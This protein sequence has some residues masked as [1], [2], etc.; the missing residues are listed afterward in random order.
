MDA[1][2]DRNVHDLPTADTDELLSQLRTVADGA[3]LILTITTDAPRTLLDAVNDISLATR[4]AWLSANADGSAIDIGP[5]VVPY[6]TAC[7]QCVT[8]RQQSSRTLGIE[9]EL[10]Q[11]E[12]ADYSTNRTT[13]HLGEALWPA[14]LA[15]SLIVGE[16]SRYLSGIAAPTLVDAV[17]RVLPVTG[18]LERN[19]VLRVP[20]CPACFR[21]EIQPAEEPFD[22]DA[23]WPVSR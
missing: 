7:F 19:E 22:L 12:L 5:L 1:L 13:P 4:T 14:T 23:D 18:L 21:G 8:L 2:S 17:L 10:Y 16:A 11:V 20:R 15:A 6:E 9:N 3:D